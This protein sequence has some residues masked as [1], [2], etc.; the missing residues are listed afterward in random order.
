VNHH[1]VIVREI[2]RRLGYPERVLD[3]VPAT[4]LASVA[5]VAAFL[6]SQRA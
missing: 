2:A 3:T 4:A 1:N 5:G 6:G